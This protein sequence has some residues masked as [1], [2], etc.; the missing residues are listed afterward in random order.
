MHPRLY[1][2]WLH[3]RVMQDRDYFNVEA[4]KKKEQERKQHEITCDSLIIK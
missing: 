4:R 2:A 3:S 1:E